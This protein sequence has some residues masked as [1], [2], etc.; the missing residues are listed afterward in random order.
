VKVDSFVTALLVAVVLA[1]LNTIVKPVLTI[2]TIPITIFS[3][4]LFLL[5]IN[6]FIIILA[7]KLVEGF[8]VNGFFTALLFSIILSVLTGILNAIFGVNK[9]ED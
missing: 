2:L 8:V 3:L 1:F 5:V 6:A 9:K 4:G 7:G